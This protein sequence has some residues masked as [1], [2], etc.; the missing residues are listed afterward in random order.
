MLDHLMRTLP[1]HCI[2]PLRE[3]LKIL[4]H[5]VAR[6]FPDPE[7]RATAGLGDYQGIGGVRSEQEDSS[8]E[9]N[10]QEDVL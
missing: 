7:D 6:S 2:P 1:P 3:Q 10:P 8:R 5:T 9:K 4:D